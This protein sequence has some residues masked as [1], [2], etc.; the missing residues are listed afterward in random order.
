MAKLFLESTDTSYKVSSNN[1]TVFGATSDQA[2]IIDGSLTG[3]VLD[4]NVERVQFTGSTTDYKYKQVGT[5]L[6]IY[7]AAGALVTK[8]GLQDDTTGTQLTFANG[9]VK[10]AF[11]PSATG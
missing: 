4:A 2:V 8:V 10:A 5:D 3:I 1:T 11:A 6:E 7:N 9:T